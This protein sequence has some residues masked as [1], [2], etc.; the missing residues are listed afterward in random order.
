[1]MT[2]T[3]GTLTA[4]HFGANQLHA[5]TGGKHNVSILGAHCKEAFKYY[6]EITTGEECYF[7]ECDAQTDPTPSFPLHFV[8]P[9]AN[10]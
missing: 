1:M 4:Y 7:T 10:G 5:R 6:H 9:E 3:R 2:K 8:Q